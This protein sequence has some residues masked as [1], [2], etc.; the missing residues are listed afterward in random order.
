MAGPLDRKKILEDAIRALGVLDN[1]CLE[2]QK[3]FAA[4]GNWE[5]TK[6]IQSVRE[7]IKHSTRLLKRMIIHRLEII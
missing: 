3:G 2:K 6:R 1:E 7:G 5:E 4:N